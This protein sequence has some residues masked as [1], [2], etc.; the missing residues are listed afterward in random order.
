LEN[1][2]GGEIISGEWAATPTAGEDSVVVL[3]AAMTEVAANEEVSDEPAAPGAITTTVPTIISKEKILAEQG[4]QHKGNEVSAEQKGEAALQRQK[5]A[6][7]Q[8][9]I[10]EIAVSQLLQEELA[11]LEPNL[12]SVASFLG[13]VCGTGIETKKLQNAARL[14]IQKAVSPEVVES[15]I[16]EVGNKDLSTLKI[17]AAVTNIDTVT[18]A[19]VEGDDSIVPPT[20]VIAWNDLTTIATNRVLAA[21]CPCLDVEILVIDESDAVSLA[22]TVMSAGGSSSEGDQSPSTCGSSVSATGTC[23]RLADESPERAQEEHSQREFPGCVTRSAAEC[24]VYLPPVGDGRDNCPGR[25]LNDDG[26]IRTKVTIGQESETLSVSLVGIVARNRASSEEDM[27]LDGKP[28]D[29]TATLASSELAPVPSSLPFTS[30]PDPLNMQPVGNRRRVDT[31]LEPDFSGI[32]DVVPVATGC[33]AIVLV[34]RN[35]VDLG[36]EPVPVIVLVDEWGRDTCVINEVCE[37]LESMPRPWSAYRAFEAASAQFPN[38]DRA[39]LR[40]VVM[41]VLMGQRRCVNRITAAGIGSV[42]AED[43][44]NSY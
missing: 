3:V 41:A 36:P 20:N 31:L 39:A 2:A 19:M 22:D 28:G 25:I 1:F 33:E 44:R 34:G 9:R 4:Q 12:A 16:V 15:V 29:A 26:T 42:C 38:I 11:K 10:R 21:I 13:K 27:I 23:K 7:N 6:N 37:L 5:I 14:A 32:I 17:V 43:Y 8:R 35:T 40:L 24:R 18:I 30:T